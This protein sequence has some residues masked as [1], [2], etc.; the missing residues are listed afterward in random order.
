VKLNT[1]N[2]A[3][4]RAT[5]ARLGFTAPPAPAPLP[6]RINKIDG[7]KIHNTKKRLAFLGALEKLPAQWAIAQ[8]GTELGWTYDQVAHV[9]RT[10]QNHGE[11]KTIRPGTRAYPAL[12]QMVPIG[13]AELRHGEKETHE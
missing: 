1:F 13:N 8:V 2:A 4:I 12:Y 3:D 7:R 11:V 10:L 9:L 5:C 6:S